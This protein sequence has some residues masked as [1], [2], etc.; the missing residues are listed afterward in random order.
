MVFCI[1]LT[2]TLPSRLAKNLNVQNAR[3]YFSGEN[4]WLLNARKGMD[5]QGS[6]AGTTD[7]IY[8]PSRIVTIGLNITL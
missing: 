4:L 5:P 1:V 6:F 8:S 2:Y 3:L 7:N